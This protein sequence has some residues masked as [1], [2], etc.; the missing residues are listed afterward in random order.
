MLCAT[1]LTILPCLM[2]KLDRVAD[3]QTR[4]KQA[5]TWEADALAPWVPLLPVG[6]GLGK[7]SGT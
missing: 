1:S 2:V 3:E 7:T 6:S 4:C 5:S